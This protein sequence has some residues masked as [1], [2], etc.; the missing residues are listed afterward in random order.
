MQNYSDAT[1]LNPQF[2]RSGVHLVAMECVD[3]GTRPDDVGVYRF[4]IQVG[5]NQYSVDV[6]CDNRAMTFYRRDYDGVSERLE[7]FE[8][9]RGILLH[10]IEGLSTRM[11]ED[12]VG[13]E[14]V[15]LSDAATRAWGYEPDDRRNPDLCYAPGQCATCD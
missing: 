6:D 15:S 1:T 4:A 14:R 10:F 13:A 5:H 2:P 8:P 12:E 11:A 7:K 9:H 3:P